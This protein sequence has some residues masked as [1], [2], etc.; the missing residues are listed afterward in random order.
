MNNNSKGPTIN[1]QVSRISKKNQS[2]LSCYVLTGYRDIKTT[3]EIISTVV[4]AGVDIIEMRISFSDSITDRPII[5]EVS[6]NALVKGITLQK[7]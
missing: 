4:Y 3:K 5:Q 7:V 6:Y 2:A 1:Q